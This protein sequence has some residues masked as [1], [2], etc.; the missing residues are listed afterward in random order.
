M[1]LQ[2]LVVV[3]SLH[4]LL[5]ILA[6][7]NIDVDNEN[8]SIDVVNSGRCAVRCLTLLQVR[9]ISS[10]FLCISVTTYDRMFSEFFSINIF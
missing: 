4:R 7:S 5:A 3:I 2:K 6:E 1:M 9:I 8:L 10:P